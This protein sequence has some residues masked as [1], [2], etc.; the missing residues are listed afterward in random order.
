MLAYLIER[1]YPGG[2]RRDGE[3]HWRLGDAMAAA[4]AAVADDLVR[5]YRILAAQI[6]PA[7]V[8]EHLEPRE[9]E[10]A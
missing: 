1:L 5:G 4:D 9:A 7:A 6:N 2:W 10:H 3:V 8:A